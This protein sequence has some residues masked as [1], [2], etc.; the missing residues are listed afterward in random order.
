MHT[1]MNA[2]LQR[3]RLIGTQFFYRFGMCVRHPSAPSPTPFIPSPA[4]AR[5]TRF[6][7]SS[8]PRS[9]S[10][11]FS[12]PLSPATTLPKPNILPASPSAS[13]TPSS[14]RTISQAISHSTT[15]A[16]YGKGIPPCRRARTRSLGR[17]V[18]WKAS[19]A[20]S[21]SSW[22]A[23]RPKP[24]LEPSTRVPSTRP[25][26]WSGVSRKPYQHVA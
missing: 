24:D 23:S 14:P 25:S 20:R 12:S 1:P 15:S 9:S 2:A 13:S 10:P 4:I 5:P 26:S 18:A 7:L 19:C 22:A 3:A 17:G 16:T 8:S 6:A 11:P 21:A